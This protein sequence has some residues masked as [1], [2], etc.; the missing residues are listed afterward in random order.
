MPGGDRQLR[1]VPERGQPFVVD[2]ELLDRIERAGAAR[3]L[4]H[5][6]ETVDR[7]E[8]G[9]AVVALDQPR[10]VLVEHLAAQPAGDHVDALLAVEQPRDVR[11]VEEPLGAGEP[12]RRAGDDHRLGRRRLSR[13]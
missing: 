7:L 9:A 5:R 2:P 6:V 4:D 11:V 12:E 10:D 3:E 8:R 13:R 1:V